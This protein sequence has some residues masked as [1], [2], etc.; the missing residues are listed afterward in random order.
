MKI[1]FNF[2]QRLFR[3]RFA[4]SKPA[5]RIKELPKARQAFITP[6]DE[7]IRDC[8]IGYP[9]DQ[10]PAVPGGRMIITKPFCSEFYSLLGEA[11]IQFHD[12]T[13]NF[14]LIAFNPTVS[15]RT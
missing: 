12:L 15:N 2:P 3:Q 4:D 5:D 13:N 1:I 6:G 9:M 11:G 7:I 8:A 10:I 14:L